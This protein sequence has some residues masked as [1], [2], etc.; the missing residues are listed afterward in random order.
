MGLMTGEYAVPKRMIVGALAG[1]FI[2][3]YFKPSMMFEGGEP[4]PWSVTTKTGDTG[5]EP[6]SIPW[7][8]VPVAG[9]FIGGVLI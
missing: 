6:T 7:W 8:A 1:A 9:A 2:V 5:V 4:R 3:T